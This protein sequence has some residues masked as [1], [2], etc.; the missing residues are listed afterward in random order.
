MPSHLPI[1]SHVPAD[2]ERTCFLIALK[3]RNLRELEDAYWA[4]AL[5]AS[6]SYRKFWRYEDI[7]QLVTPEGEHFNLC[8]EPLP[9]SDDLGCKLL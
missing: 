6:P 5:P 2:D 1:I 7:E 3:Q 4:V 9:F 8:A